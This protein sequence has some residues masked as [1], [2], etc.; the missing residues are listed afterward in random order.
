[1]DY[2]PKDRFWKLFAEA[3]GPVFQGLPGFAKILIW[4]NPDPWAASKYHGFSGGQVVAGHPRAADSASCIGGA[5]RLKRLRPRPFKPA[6]N[7]FK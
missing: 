7:C 4:R 2:C 6:S 5:K 3:L 1:M